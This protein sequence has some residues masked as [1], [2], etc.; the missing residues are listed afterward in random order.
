MTPKELRELS[1]EDLAAKSRELRDELFNV[2][3]T[4][5][6]S[7]ALQGKIFD[8]NHGCVGIPFQVIVCVQF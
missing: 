5:R 7:G 6:A 8:Q 1:A 3:V 4:G 2:R